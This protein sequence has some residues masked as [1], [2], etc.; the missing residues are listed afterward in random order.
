[1]T[2][3]SYYC[4]AD[5]ARR[6][7]GFSVSEI[8]D[9][10]VI[11]YI[12]LA[13]AEID[14]ALNTTFLVAQ[15]SGT[16]STGTVSVL[17]DTAKTWVADEWN[18]DANLVGGYMVYIYSGTGSGQC[19]VIIDG[20]T[21]QLSVSPNFT[22]APDNTSKYRIFKN[23]R[24]S[25]TFDG[26]GTNNY[27][28][29]HYPLFNVYSTT[30][31]STSIT[32][33]YLNQYADIGKLTLGTSAEKTVW[34]DSSPQLCNVVYFYGTYPIPVIIKEMTAILTGILI[35]N[36]F[37]GNKYASAI[38]YTLPELSVNKQPVMQNL[39]GIYTT[40]TNRYEQL[41]TQLSLVNPAFG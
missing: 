31:D 6:I 20:T 5:E 10:D 14:Q 39:S 41:K 16:C 23:T 19:R 17:N 33:S 18:S 3:L 9:A 1:M 7:L 38:S 40:L 30:I 32:V 4:S 24:I 13:Q 37:M 12:I 11:Q 36:Y 27:F 2:T 28:V 15:D 8:A 26:D 21:T 34:E 22:T 35:C 25:E 29:E